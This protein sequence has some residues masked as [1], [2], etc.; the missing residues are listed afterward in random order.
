MTASAPLPKSSTQILPLDGTPQFQDTRESY[1][2]EGSLV[3]SPTPN[4]SELAGRSTESCTSSLSTP[5]NT[6]PPSH[7]CLA[8]NG[9]LSHDATSQP[10]IQPQ[11]PLS[12]PPEVETL[13]DSRLHCIPI[14]LWIRRDSKLAPCKIPLEY[15]YLCMGYF[16]ISDLRVSYRYLTPTVIDRILAAC[17][18]PV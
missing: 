5:P 6:P 18:G 4:E 1:A 11:V 3:Q 2:R 12:K 17:G 7:P 9:S 15:A 14:L 10:D 16:F 13:L 8:L